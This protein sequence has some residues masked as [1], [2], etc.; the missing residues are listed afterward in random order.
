MG[1]FPGFGTV[2]RPKP[3]EVES[4]RLHPLKSTKFTPTPTRFSLISSRGGASLDGHCSLIRWEEFVGPQLGTRIALN[5]WPTPGYAGRILV[6]GRPSG[7]QGENGP[8]R[9]P[10]LGGPH[11]SHRSGGVHRRN[12]ISSF[13]GSGGGFLVGA[14]HGYFRTQERHN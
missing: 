8:I 6:G 2:L 13:C 14:L 9:G 3:G 11:V 10:N 1:S 4:S 5:N 7:E 12:C